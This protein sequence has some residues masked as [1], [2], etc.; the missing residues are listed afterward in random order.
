MNE[1]PDDKRPVLRG[2]NQSNTSDDTEKTREFSRRPKKKLNGLTNRFICGDLHTP[3]WPKVLPLISLLLPIVSMLLPVT[4]AI[5][6]SG[7][8]SILA[9]V[10]LIMTERSAERLWVSVAGL[11]VGVALILVYLLLISR[12][13]YSIVFPTVTR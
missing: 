7:L 4:V 8:G 2:P 12:G 11:A 9:L 13:V 3:R 10:S 1:N 6:V 5:V